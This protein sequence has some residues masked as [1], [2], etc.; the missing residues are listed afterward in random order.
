LPHFVETEIDTPP[1]NS[2]IADQNGTLI[3]SI[4]L[5]CAKLW[6]FECEQYATWFWSHTDL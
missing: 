2:F 6:A 5:S 1:E 4:R 3:F